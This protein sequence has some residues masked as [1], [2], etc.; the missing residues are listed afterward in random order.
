[1]KYILDEEAKLVDAKRHAK[2]EGIEQGEERKEIKLVQRMLEKGYS[3]ENIADLLGIS[4]ERVI[5][6]K[7]KVE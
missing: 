7:K 1:M 6:I 5:D 3:V 4:V 2:Q